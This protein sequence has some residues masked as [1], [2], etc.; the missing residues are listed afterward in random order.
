M[1]QSI[2]PRR[3]ISRT[4]A[5]LTLVICCG[6]ALVAQN[7]GPADTSNGAAPLRAT[8]ILGFEG[9]SSNAQ[10]DLSIQG[11]DLQFQKKE[12]SPAQVAIGSIQDVTIGQQDKQVGGVPM[13]LVRTATPYGGG[14]VMSLFSH[15]KFDTVTVEYLDPNGGFHGAIFQL[16]KGQGQIL[17]S[18]LEAKG[19]H[20][21]LPTPA[22]SKQSTQETKNEIK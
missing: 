22:T 3:G 12:G 2:L 21:S 9:T 10:G 8:H 5:S 13:T 11:D 4:L 1:I 18:E 7:Q 14:R 16:N 6:T 17:G 15:K 19:V 20:V